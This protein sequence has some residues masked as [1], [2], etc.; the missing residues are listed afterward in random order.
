MGVASRGDAARDE[1]GRLA[2]LRTELG[3]AELSMGMSDDLEVALEAG[4][5]IVR[6]GTALFGPRPTAGI[7]RA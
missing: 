1:L 4:A 3:L 5:T 6:L 2:G 7:D